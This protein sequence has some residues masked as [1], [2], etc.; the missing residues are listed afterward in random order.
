MKISGYGV[1]DHIRLLAP[2]FG[3]IAAVWALRLVLDAAG[4]PSHLVRAFSVTVAGA[5]AVLLAAVLI[6]TRHFGGYPSVAL[7]SL[8]LVA[9]EQFLIV[10]AIAFSA[11]TH[12]QNVYAAPEY[13]PPAGP[14]AHILGH[15]TF[16]LATGMLFGTVMGSILLWTL[17]RLVPVASSRLR[18]R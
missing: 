9:W 8:L 1:R 5:I 15:L 10:V 16:G 4:A 3:L 14:W 12:T 13:S 11:L 2:L 6:H 18:R 7:A 17:R